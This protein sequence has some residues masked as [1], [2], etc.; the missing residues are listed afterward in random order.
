M[1]SP[2]KMRWVAPT[3]DVPLAE[4]YHMRVTRQV[5]KLRWEVNGQEIGET[6]LADD[7]LRLT[8][9]LMFAN[10]GKGAGAVFRYVVIRS[11]ILDVDASWP[12]RDRGEI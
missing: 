6:T 10:Y 12:A 9:R 5:Q 8:E 7:E 4:S 2:E 3:R 11:R 1:G